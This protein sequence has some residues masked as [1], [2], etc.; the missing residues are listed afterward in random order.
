[1]CPP[2]PSAGL[3]DFDPWD[4]PPGHSRPVRRKRLVDN[5]E[6]LAF[7]VRILRAA[8]R[9]IGDADP[10]DLAVMVELRNELDLAIGT[11]ARAQN[12]A[13]FSWA[14]IAEPLGMT[15]QAAFQRWSKPPPTGE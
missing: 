5:R 14:Q 7:T 15:R 1:M 2:V 8:H 9:R 11:A 3:P 10:E 6:Y 4:S 13:G 12:A